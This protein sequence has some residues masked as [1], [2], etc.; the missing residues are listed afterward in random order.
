MVETDNKHP[1]IP[2]EKKPEAKQKTTQVLDTGLDFDPLTAGT[3][4]GADPLTLGMGGGAPV[5]EDDEDEPIVCFLFV[6]I[7]LIVIILKD[8]FYSITFITICRK[9]YS[10]I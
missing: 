4:F 6:V 3:S 5:Y 7:V 1:L 2:E 9:R 8:Y 10:F